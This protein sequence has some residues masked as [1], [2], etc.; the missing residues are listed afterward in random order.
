MA[1]PSEQLAAI[2]Q[3]ADPHRRALKTAELAGNVAAGDRALVPRLLALLERDRDP[4][5]RALV[6]RA[7]S[8]IGGSAARDA[9]VFAL[10]DADAH[11]REAAWKALDPAD[12]ELA[13][14]LLSKIVESA[15]G[16]DP[17]AM[18]LHALRA[19]A[20]RA[21]GPVALPAEA[22]ALAA[23]DPDRFVRAAATR[24]AAFL[25]DR[26]RAQALVVVGLEDDE[27]WVRESAAHGAAEAMGP[28]DRPALAALCDA[29]AF[30]REN[31]TRLHLLRAL[32]AICARPAP[33]DR[34]LVG[35][36]R[37]MLAAS[38]P[39]VRAAALL[40]VGTIAP[41]GDSGLC[42]DLAS[43]L[44]D[45]REEIRAAAARLLADLAPAGHTQLLPALEAA[46][47]K[48]DP[49]T[50]RAIARVLRRMG[51]RETE[52]LLRRLSEDPEISV[53]RAAAEALSELFSG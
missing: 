17:R 35:I 19:I 16:A 12:D 32:V 33:E 1:S 11:V 25:P 48:A 10:A 13:I 5:V 41:Q 4:F 2:E 53:A 51:G 26:A 38:D 9:I 18:A 6:C 47:P 30:A 49:P 46:L 44:A 36:A 8:R 52:P 45:G 21:D 27:G 43:R 37:G 24:A 50:R 34:G 28:S 29:L 31:A 42:D 39:G 7:L 20:V 15:R 3:E 14:P 40:L 23:K 22:I